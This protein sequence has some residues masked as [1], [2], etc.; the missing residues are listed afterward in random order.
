[1]S[2]G[3]VP[4]AT[5]VADGLSRPSVIPLVA[6]VVVS[7]LA[8]GLLIA[9]AVV[10]VVILVT[11]ARSKGNFKI[12]AAAVETQSVDSEK[13]GAFDNPIYGRTFSLS[14]PIACRIIILHSWKQQPRDWFKLSLGWIR[15]L[16]RFV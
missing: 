5:G 11:R 15:N 3:S 1:M 2:S 6:G 14:I 9:L 16:F 4:R 13:H 8:V 10:I 12:K 7:L